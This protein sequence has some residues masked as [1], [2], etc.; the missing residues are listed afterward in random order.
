MTM[1]MADAAETNP[2][3]DLFQANLAAFKRWAPNLYGRLAA[4]TAPNS[5]LTVG[6]DGRIDMAFRGQGFYDGDALAATSAQL[7]EYFAKP[8]RHAI[9]E[10]EPERLEGACGDFCTAVTDR[11]A[12]QAISYDGANCPPESHVLVVFG[13]GLGLHVGPLIERTGARVAVLIEPNLEFLYHSL[14]LTDWHA[15]Y[16]S[17]AEEGRQVVVIVEQDSSTIASRGRQILRANNPALLD[18]I[19][20]YTH[21]PSAVLEQA[22]ERV[23]HELFLTLSGLGFF[24]D[25]L[26]MTRNAVANLGRGSVEI[27]CDYHRRRDEPLFIVGSGPSVEGDLDFIADHADRAVLISIGSGLRVLLQRGI[28]PD[29]HVELENGEG[30]VEIMAATAK[31]HD[32]GG[33]TLLASLTVQPGMVEM[34]DRAILFFRERVSSTTLFHSGL[35]VLQPAGPTVA[36]SAL[37]AGIRLG[38]R[39]LYLFGLDM[40]SKVEGRFHAEGS[41]YGAGLRAEVA[42]PN[43]RF[44]GNFGGEVTGETIFNWS[45]KVLEGA[46]QAHRGVRAYNCSDGARIAGAVPKVARAVELGAAPLDRTALQAAIAKGLRR[47]PLDHLRRTWGEQDSRAEA[48]EVFCFIERI[49]DRAAEESEPGIDWIHEIFEAVRPDDPA[50]LVVTAYLSGTLS[51]CIGCTNWYDRRI[52]DPG[53]RQ[54]YRR[55][56]IGEF[57]ALVGALRDKLFALFDEVDRRLTAA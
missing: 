50:K 43:R 6:P 13:I 19:Y 33:I 16:E 5:E 44:A 30:N 21:Y 23:Q 17:A 12:E 49:L 36:N 1:V 45:R 2:V 14:Y 28:R 20:L 24:E 42:K 3:P 15:I 52:A 26:I 10:P 38:F 7:E 55:I 25:E 41:V 9:N 34:F 37:I 4:V 31:D 27:L 51:I 11:L 54:R 32:L 53:D 8:L 40:G 46:L 47:Y 22:K 56:A 39:E 29:F 48:E 35:G 18:G 57:R